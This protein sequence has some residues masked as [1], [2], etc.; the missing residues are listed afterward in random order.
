[1]TGADGGM[2]GERKL[3][4]RCENAYSVVGGWIAR[5]K[6]ERGFAEVRPVCKSSHVISGHSIGIKHHGN[7][8]AK[9]G[10]GREDID[11]GKRSTHGET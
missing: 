7:R 8:I 5:R 10:L 9:V 1:M 11:L 4:A 3:I 6:N 2:A